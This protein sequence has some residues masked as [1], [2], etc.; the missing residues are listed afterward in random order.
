MK[1]TRSFGTL[2]T[3]IVCVV[4]STTASLA[5]SGRSIPVSGAVNRKAVM[6][7]FN[8][9][10]LSFEHN[11]GQTDPRVKFISH[12]PGY[13]LF[14]TEHEAVLSLQEEPAAGNGLAQ[15]V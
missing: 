7:G 9:R 11:T 10:P 15:P 1:S 13:S 4:F 3:L 14:L 12:G 2:G 5:Q 8:N 6:E